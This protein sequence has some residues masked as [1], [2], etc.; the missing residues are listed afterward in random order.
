MGQQI[1]AEQF[2]AHVGP[3][4]GPIW[5]GCVSTTLSIVLLLK[6]LFCSSRYFGLFTHTQIAFVVGLTMRFSGL[7]PAALVETCGPAMCLP[8]PPSL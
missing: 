7:V 1:E 5:S 3:I 6:G 2:R 8:V 4:S